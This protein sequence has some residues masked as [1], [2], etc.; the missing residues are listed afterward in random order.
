MKVKLKIQGEKSDSM[1]MRLVGTLGGRLVLFAVGML[2]LGF[3][4]LPVAYAVGSVGG[5]EGVAYSLVL[6]LIP[7]LLTIWGA[8]F[9]RHPDL[10]AYVVLLGTSVRLVFVLAGV[11]V[12]SAA[13]PLLGFWQFTVWLI[14]CYLVALALETAVVLL[15]VSSGSEVRAASAVS[16]E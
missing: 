4:L 10:S 15:S 5:L 13:R 7:G 14:P 1:L 3:V 12:V 6:C 2:L 11:F 9:L 8:E 16:V